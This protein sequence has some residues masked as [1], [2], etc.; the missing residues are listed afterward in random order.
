[1]TRNAESYTGKLRSNLLGTAF[2][3]YDNGKAF[4]KGGMGE[5]SHCRQELAAVI[6]VSLTILFITPILF[7]KSFFEIFSLINYDNSTFI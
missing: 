7:D 1:M 2:T 4:R 6:Y 3:I 5:G